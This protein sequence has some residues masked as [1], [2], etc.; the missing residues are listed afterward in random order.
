MVLLVSIYQRNLYL[1]G[2]DASKAP[3]VTI[4]TDLWS[5]RSPIRSLCK[6]KSYKRVRWRIV[7]F[8]LS[9][10]HFVT[11]VWSLYRCC[12]LLDDAD[13]TWSIYDRKE[14]RTSS[15]NSVSACPLSMP[16]MLIDYQVTTKQLSCQLYSHHKPTKEHMSLPR[17]N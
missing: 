5:L 6:P 12:P 2:Y 17:S 13:T 4:A 14:M 3:M 7:P 1:C 11:C 9:A 16:T 10:F 15:A 8:R